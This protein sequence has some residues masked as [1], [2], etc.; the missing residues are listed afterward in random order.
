MLLTLFEARY[1]LAALLFIQQLTRSH[2]LTRSQSVDH[3]LS[4]DEMTRIASFHKKGTWGPKALTALKV[5]TQ[6]PRIPCCQPFQPLN[7][8]KSIFY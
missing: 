5:L 6:S 7:P 4:S 1:N 2:Q 8:Y 3:T